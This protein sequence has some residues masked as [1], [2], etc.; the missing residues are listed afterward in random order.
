M[1]RASTTLLTLALLMLLLVPAAAAPPAANDA[2]GP[3]T[4]ALLGD[5]PYG[6]DQTAGFPR[7]VDAVNVDPRVRFVLH[8]GDVKSGG[9][10]C[11]DALLEGRRDLFQRFDDPFV[12]T[13]G[14][15]DWTDCHRESNGGYVPTERLAFVRELF[16]PEA[17]STLGRHPMRVRTQADEPG[18]G[19]YVENQL[20]V[21][22]RVV[23]STV[24][25]VGSDNGLA[26]WSGLEG[27]DRAEERTAEVEDRI[28]AA[29]AWLDA[30][31]AEAAARDAAGVLVLI[32][33]NPIEVDPA[34]GFAEFLDAFAAHAATFDG[35]VVLAHG[36]FH[37]FRVDQ[38]FDDLPNV[39]RV[40]T[41]GGEID[42]WV[43]VTVDPRSPGVFAFEPVTVPGT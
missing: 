17:G 22:S 32:Q 13:P 14:D 9:E 8:A 38:P 28:D 34:T 4:F 11:S 43:R 23:F 18:H 7:L 30:T 5:T 1:R 24:H 15:N 37:E 36:D 42:R 25:V 2:A 33:A 26:P 27:G 35:P 40:Q 19:E 12:L 21:R 31:F 3:T 20:F 29:V 6:T 39:T 10:R 16:Y 41:F